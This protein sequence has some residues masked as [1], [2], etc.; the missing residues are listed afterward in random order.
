MPFC[1]P[2]VDRPIYQASLERFEFALKAPISF[3]KKPGDTH[4]AF[5]VPEPA[6]E[7]VDMI[8]Q[9]IGKGIISR[10]FA[11]CVLAVDFPNPVYSAW[12]EQLLPFV[13]ETALADIGDQGVPETVAQAIAQRASALPDGHAERVALDEFLTCWNLPAQTWEGALRNRI[14]TYLKTVAN[15]LNTTAGF[16]D[17]VKLAE[18]RRL[19][20]ALSPHGRLKESDLLFPTSKALEGL[21]APHKLKMTADGMIGVHH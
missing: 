18:A 19:Q 15:R 8:R 10:R 3:I 16:F 6:F 5:A 20:F 9:L 11:A 14:D 21:E 17:Y 7:D 1:M 4:F 13:P 12:R 2:A